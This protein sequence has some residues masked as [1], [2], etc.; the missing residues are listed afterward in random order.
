VANAIPPGLT[1]QWCCDQTADGQIS[2]S[3][4][5]ECEPAI[6]L[7][8]VNPGCSAFSNALFENLRDLV[9]NAFD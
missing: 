7:V 6:D 5:K 2:F 4:V 8:A 9:D 3:V 1:S